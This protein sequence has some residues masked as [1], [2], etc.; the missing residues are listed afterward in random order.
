MCNMKMILLGSWL[1]LALSEENPS[2]SR[3]LDGRNASVFSISRV[4]TD[5]SRSAGFVE[6]GEHVTGTT[7]KTTVYLQ[8]DGEI[9]VQGLSTDG[10]GPSPTP[11]PSCEVTDAVYAERPYAC[12]TAGNIEFFLS[13]NHAASKDACKRRCLSQDSC[14]GWNYY[15][16]SYYW[17]SLQS[18]CWIKGDIGCA[19]SCDSGASC[20]TGGNEWKGASGGGKF[21]T[22]TKGTS[23]SITSGRVAT[24]PTA[25]SGTDDYAYGIQAMGSWCEA[26]IHKAFYGSGLDLADGLTTWLSNQA[27]PTAQS[28]SSLTQ[29]KCKEECTKETAANCHAWTYFKNVA[30]NKVFKNVCLLQKRCTS[31]YEWGDNV[32]TLKIA[33]APRCT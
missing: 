23:V 18:S 30:E 1:L 31:T 25:C 5:S 9:S 33:S 22:C 8:E 21:T 26:P 29:S 4:R 19:S 2:M 24:G 20:F 13:G 7:I 6:I 10:A 17:K 16:S 12:N 3:T 11:S 27:G 28:V 32:L 14:Y 15:G